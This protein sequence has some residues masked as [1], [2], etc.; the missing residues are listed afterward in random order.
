M[1][2]HKPAHCLIVGG[3]DAGT[4]TGGSVIKCD[5]GARTLRAVFSK[6]LGRSSTGHENPAAAASVPPVATDS[7]QLRPIRGDTLTPAGRISV[8]TLRAAAPAE[9]AQALLDV[10]QGWGGRTGTITAAELLLIHQE[11]CLEHDFEQ[12]NWVAVGRE[13]RRLIGERKTYD[14]INGHRVRVYRVP[15]ADS[16]RRIRAAQTASTPAT[17]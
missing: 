9:H 7:N 3:T 6:I 15:P 16:R 14:W 4:T 11:V 17:A 13:F 8:P 5:W 2:A 1:A 12:I 10:L